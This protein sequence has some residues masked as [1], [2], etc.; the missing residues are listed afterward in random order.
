M[1][2]LMIVA[3]ALATIASLGAMR[4][5]SAA[6]IDPPSVSTTLSTVKHLAKSADNGWTHRVYPAPTRANDHQQAPSRVA[7]HDVKTPVHRPSH[8]S[9]GSHD[10]NG[11]SRESARGDRR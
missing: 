2:K 7:R 1:R 5:A 6:T 4:T 11:R 10:K 8:T 9:H 3:G